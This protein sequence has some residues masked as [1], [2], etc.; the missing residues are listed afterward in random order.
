MEH[1][2]DTICAERGEGIDIVSNVERQW[3]TRVGRLT[4]RRRDVPDR[5]TGRRY[6]P[7]DAALGVA[8]R[9]RLSPG[10]PALVVQAVQETSDPGAARR[11]R[12]W[13]PGLSAMACWQVGQRVGARVQA[14]QATARAAL[15]ERGEA[16]T[17]V[18]RV[19]TWHVEADGV[20]GHSRAGGHEVKLAV[21]YA[22]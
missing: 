16:L 7:L 14:Q 6:V 2:D 3:T 5:A 18:R 11:L 4:F 21:A 12:A 1:L 13:M 20:W 8:P 17:G 9:E 22:G 15:G 19:D 10:V